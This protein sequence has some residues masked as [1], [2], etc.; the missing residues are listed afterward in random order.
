MNERRPPPT[1]PSPARWEGKI[2]AGTILFPSPL[3]GEGRVGGKKQE[4]GRFMP[5][6]LL[7]RAWWVIVGPT[8][9][10]TRIEA[11]DDAEIRWHDSETR[12]GGRS[13]RRADRS[14]LARGD[15]H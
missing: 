10:P 12:A 11:R 7:E 2:K 1:L 3:A 13:P 14:G 5:V 4:R 8:N 15:R 9:R 6:P